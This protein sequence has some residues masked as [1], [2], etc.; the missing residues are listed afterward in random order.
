METEDNCRVPYCKLVEFILHKFTLYLLN[1]RFNIIVP[2][3]PII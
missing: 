3:A 1:I 2:S